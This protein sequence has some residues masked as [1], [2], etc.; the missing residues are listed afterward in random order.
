MRWEPLRPLIVR[1]CSYRHLEALAA[2]LLQLAVQAC[3]RRASTVGEL[4][5]VLRFPHRLPLMDPDR[6]LVAAELTR[7][8]RPDLLIEHGRPQFLELNNSN[9][10]GGTRQSS[11]LAESYARLCPGSG[12]YPPPSAVTARFAALARTLRT[13]ESQGG[14]RRALIP[15]Y[16]ATD[17]THVTRHH[18]LGRATL[19]AV[20]RSG[21]EPVVAELADLRLDAAG[22]LLAGD[23]A[24][25]VVLLEWGGNRIVCDGGALAALRAADRAGTVGLFPR[26]ESYLISSKAVFAWLHEDA[27]AG[28]LAPDDEDL[29]RAHVP[30][31]ACL[32]LNADPTA[33]RNLLRTAAA[34]RDRLI[35]KPA[36]G[37]AGYRVIFGRQIS[38]T[39]WVP[40]LVHAAR[41]SP[42]VL[43]RRVAPDLVAMS[44]LDHGSGQQVT[45]R[46]PF[47][48]SP[49]VIDGAAAGVWVRHTTPDARNRQ[50]VIDTRLGA[51]PNTVLLAP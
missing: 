2:R 4:Y 33:Q 13:G 19:A 41:R 8:A 14:S 29:I 24:I 40:R 22:R 25:D 10:L 34:E 1:E 6:P 51:H 11:W 48:L 17:D 46:V 16:W 21:L 28:L 12:Q 27:E 15:S 38:D 49:F 43:Q 35:V 44:Y 5:A 50:T 20:R 37:R 18:R 42:L 36:L 45:A 31:T 30:W 9:R 32:G 26:T 47:V 39:D 7:Y 23:V 3:R